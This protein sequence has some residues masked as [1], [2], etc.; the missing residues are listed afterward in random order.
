MVREKK[1][2]DSKDLQ[3]SLSRTFSMR[4]T[5]LWPI[6][7][8]KEGMFRLQKLWDAHRNNLGDIATRLEIPKSLDE[9]IG[10]IHSILDE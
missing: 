6:Q 4:G 3:V 5:P 2:Q 1:L 8:Q 7:F 9:V 10:M